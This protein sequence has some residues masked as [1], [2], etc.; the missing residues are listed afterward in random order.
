[1]SVGR[2]NVNA[3]REIAV[4]SL[5]LSPPSDVT[6]AHC[7]SDEMGALVDRIVKVNSMRCLPEIVA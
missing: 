2:T 7:I 3:N 6:A 1:M 5:S 4:E